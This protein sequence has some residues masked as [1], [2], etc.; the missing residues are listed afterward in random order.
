[1]LDEYKGIYNCVFNKNDIG[2]SF[3]LKKKELCCTVLSTLE[4][5][6]VQGV[7]NLKH[8]WIMG[9]GQWMDR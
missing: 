2:F 5:P 3:F 7:S 4:L 1:M 9:Y 8:R 6:L